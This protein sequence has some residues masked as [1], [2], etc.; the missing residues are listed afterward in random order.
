M[1]TCIVH[2]TKHFLMGKGFFAWCEKHGRLNKS[3]KPGRPAFFPEYLPAHI[4]AETHVENAPMRYHGV[5][6]V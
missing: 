1:N 5:G 2:V 4:V 3:G 6:A